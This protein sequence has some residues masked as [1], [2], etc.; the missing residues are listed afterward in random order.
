MTPETLEIPKL[1]TWTEAF[2]A[3]RERM[4]A[5][6]DGLSHEQVNFK[7][8]PDRWSVAE[9]LDHLA[10]SMRIYLDPMEPVVDAARAGAR[11]AGKTGGEPYRRGP[12][13]G[14]LLLRAL[15]KP[16]K[17]YPAPRMFRPGRSALAPD[18]VRE[19]FDA[20]IGRM[21][22]AVERSDGLA[23]GKIKMPWPVFPPIKLSLAQAFELQALHVGRHLDQAERVTREPGFPRREDNATGDA[24]DTGAAT[25]APA[26]AGGA[27]P[28]R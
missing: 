9:C 15:R 5:L 23:L 27:G 24:G 26:G 25:P 12:F 4:R 20:Q 10:V 28:P 19:G 11:A 13:L 3:G 22:R 6:V 18:A 7:P 1:Q 14:R 16:G 8:A 2:E 17:R 21:L